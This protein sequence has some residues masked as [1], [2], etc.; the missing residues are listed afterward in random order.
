M[1]DVKPILPYL[2]LGG[3]VLALTLSS[4]FVRW[5]QAPGVVTSFYRMAIAAL[6]LVPLGLRSWRG[7]RAF[8]PGLLVLPLIGGLFTSL[9]HGFWSTSIQYTRVANATL[10]NNIAPLWVALLSYL[11]WRQRLSGRFWVG[12]AC[13]LSGAAVVLASDLILHPHFSGGDALA[14]LSSVF[15]AAY[16]LVT[17]QGRKKLPALAYIWLMTAAS[18]VCLLAASLGMGHS[19]GGYSRE[20]WL[21]FVGAAVISQVGGYFMV[22]YA[23]G[24]LPAAVVS[25]TMIAQPVL[26]A[27]AAIPLVGEH[28]AVW[29]LLGGG[30]VLLGVYL[31]NTAQLQKETSPAEA[32]LVEAQ[33]D[34][35][36]S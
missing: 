7:L 24:H 31:V 9:D 29:Q 17:Q 26:T 23:L 11:F 27:L 15:Y 16:F 36:G 18:A 20:T 21:A 3:G 13:A 5:A 14:L 6:L 10:L 4:L 28:L 34:T 22:S 25:P 35:A 19:L 2:A 1:R 8:S 12:L 32:G 33:N 30:V